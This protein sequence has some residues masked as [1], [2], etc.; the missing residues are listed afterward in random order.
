[1]SGERLFSKIKLIK[2]R[3]RTSM[4]QSRLSGPALLSIESD[5]LRTIDFSQ[6]VE[7]FAATK[8]RK[9]VI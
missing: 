9:V 1:V 4:T 6:V 7:Q 8:S 2:N 3:L 5:I